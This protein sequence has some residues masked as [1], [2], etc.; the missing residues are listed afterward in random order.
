MTEKQ[1]KEYHDWCYCPN[2]PGIL[3]R[4]VGFDKDGFPIIQEKRIDDVD[5]ELKNKI[6]NIEEELI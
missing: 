5:K 2:N 6:P 1:V 3:R 4:I